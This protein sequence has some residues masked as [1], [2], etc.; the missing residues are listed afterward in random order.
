MTRSAK[1]SAQKLPL[2]CVITHVLVMVYNRITLQL[3]KVFNLFLTLYFL[4]SWYFGAITKKDAEMILMQP[5]CGYKSFLVRDCERKPHDY[6]L[7]IRDTFQVRHYQI[8]RLGDEFCISLLTTF[9]TVIELISHYTQRTG[10]S[11]CPVQRYGSDYKWYSHCYG[12]NIHFTRMVEV[13]QF[14]ELWD[15]DWCYNPVTIR[16]LKNVSVGIPSFLEEVKLMQQLKHKCN[17]ILWPFGICSLETPLCIITERT[18][19]NLKSYL[20]VKGNALTTHQIIDIG[21]QVASAM[22]YLESV[23]CVHRSLCAKNVALVFSHKFIFKV[24]NFTLARIIS[25]HDHIESTPQEQFPIKWTAPESLR[26]NRFT[27]KSDV[28]SFGVVVY[29]TTTRGGDPY[30]RMDDSE[31]LT[32]LDAGYRMPCP[33]GCPERLYTI[34]IKKCWRKNADRRPTFVII[35]E[36]LK[37]ICTCMSCS[38]RRN[39]VA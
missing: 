29:E 17:N 16:K 28:W 34:I 23:K 18:C 6:I 32:K 26:T 13:Y 37:Q 35:C 2:G 36:S 31:M 5:I 39:T 20:N 10:E 11:C 9:K 15:G 27:T 12:S 33:T 38:R 1:I 25:K 8:H 7:S 30:P 24:T 19:G 4:L 14:Y 22:I 3:R 21:M